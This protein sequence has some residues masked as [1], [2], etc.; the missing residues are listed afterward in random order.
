MPGTRG[1]NTAEVGI[2]SNNSA[3]AQ[4]RTDYLINPVN[5]PLQ[6]R[7]RVPGDKSVSHRVVILASLAEGV[8]DCSGFLDSA[9]TR[10]TVTAFR[11]MGVSITQEDEFLSVDGAGLYGLSAPSAVLDMGNSG[12]SARLLLGVLAGQRF[13]S[14]LTGDESLVR[15]PMR[16]VADPLNSMNADVR[17]T[18]EGTLPAYIPG[19]RRLRGIDYELPVASAQLKSA[20]LL[21]GLYADGRTM[22]TEPAPTR[23]HTERLL[24][25]FACPVKRSGNRITVESGV[26][27]ANRI[28]IPG[29]ISS[30]AFLLVA[31]CIVPGSDLLI[32]GVGLNPTRHAVLKILKLMGADIS[33]SNVVEA[34]G[35]PSADM[36][37]KYRPMRG[38]TI[39]THLVPS[40][41]DEFPAIMVAAC[42]ASG[43]TVLGDAAELRVKESDRIQALADGFK[44]TGITVKT[45]HDGLR[46]IGGRPGA[47]IVDS[48]GDH[49][50]AMAFSLAGLAAA[51]PITVRDCKNV[52]TSFPGFTDCA[53]QV[54]WEIKTAY[55]D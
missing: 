39:P 43:E 24:A 46:L 48:H 4:S 22:I 11:D 7:I 33:I 40:A 34:E 18:S 17:I 29:D 41:I 1:V 13:A 31:G 53:R 54:G 42:Y 23:D 50:I 19:N 9:D 26:L 38:I 35:E 15:R 3:G 20:L 14:T 36:R 30:A 10:V 5:Q 47:G 21:A 2:M 6:G 52:D 44:R 51:G 28:R 12:T 45:R 37:V 49:R 55:A 27:Q 8:S 32:E 25:Q 16:R